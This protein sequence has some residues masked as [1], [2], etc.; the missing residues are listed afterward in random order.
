[1]NHSQLFASVR[2]WTLAS[3]AALAIVSAVG[4]ATIGPGCGGQVGCSG[5]VGCGVEP[6]CGLDPACGCAS[7]CGLDGRSMAGQKWCGDGSCGP[8][9]P[10]INVC[11][12]P[13]CGSCGCE[14]GCGVEP[15]CGCEPTCGVGGCGDICGTGG[16]CPVAE[17]VAFGFHAIGSEFR[18]LF[19]P[20][21]L[22]CLCGSGC[23]G[24]GELY[25]S[26]W[27]SDPPVCCDPCDHGG[28]WVGPTSGMAVPQGQNFAPRRVAKLP[29][30]GPRLR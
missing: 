26:D 4:C 28:N 12:G 19:A 27:H 7:S 15:G 18:R 22:C 23:G 30:G 11:T 20:L 5:P 21:G 17:N 8:I 29:G 25:W 10:L 9:R 3:C 2:A 14:P 6:G 24:C 16:G 1:M 13:D